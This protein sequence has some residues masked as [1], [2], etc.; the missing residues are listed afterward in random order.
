MVDE[1]KPTAVA[2][3]FQALWNR[4]LPTEK[5][6]SPIYDDLLGR[7]SE[8]GR[9]YHKQTHLTHCLQEF[10]KAILSMDCPDAIELALWFHDAVYVPG[11]TD[12]ELR[13]AELFRQWGDISFSSDFVDKICQLILVTM[14]KQPPNGS[15]ECYIVDIDLSSFGVNWSRFLQDS[16]N[17]RKESAFVPDAVYYP[18]HAGFLKRLLNR[19]RIFY[20][21][22]FYVRYEEAA[23]CNIKRLL[24]TTSYQANQ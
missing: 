14:H 20:T 6:A 18:S 17:V 1:S 23:R 19:P 10:D 2:D 22:F 8:L 3:R 12:N 4:C 11:A 13:S 7:Y 9:C 15:D 21:D 16:E 24:S 5:D